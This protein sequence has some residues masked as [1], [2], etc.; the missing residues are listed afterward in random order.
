MPDVYIVRNGDQFEVL[1]NESGLPP[2]RLNT[3]YLKALKNENL[4][5]ATK[6][7]LEDKV[8][9][10]LWV[11][12]SLQKRQ[13]AIYRVTKL[14]VEIQ[15]DFLLKGESYLKPLRLKDIADITELHESTISRVT[16]G[17][18]ALCEQG[19]LELKSFFSKGMDS[20]EGDVSTRKIKTQ[21]R[22][23]VDNESPQSPYSDEKIVKLLSEQGV[24]IARR[25]VAKYRDEM[26]IATMS[27]RKRMRR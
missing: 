18:Y 27:Q 12:K 22:E 7:Y 16:S 3:Y 26:N 25:T 21:I 17:K 14:I 20:D 1:M 6:D 2:I 9:N 8:K 19:L 13:K 4:D 15:H 24:D 10:A 5:S 11:L 23:I